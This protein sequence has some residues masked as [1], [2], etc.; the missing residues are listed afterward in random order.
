MVDKR[1]SGERWM[2]P[3]RIYARPLVLRE[4]MVL[5]PAALLKS[6][7]GL[8]YEQKSDLPASPGEFALG[9][10]AVT[11]FPRPGGDAATEAVSVAFDKGK[12]KTIAGVKSKKRYPAQTLEP[13]LIT[14]L[15]DDSREK[16][17]IVRYEE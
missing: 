5:D 3:S 12:L 9:D 13:E 17:R 11:L 10:N 7:N 14:Y 1:L 16:R 4:G 8:K 6:L 2:V 15:F